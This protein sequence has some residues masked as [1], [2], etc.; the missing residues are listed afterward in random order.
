MKQYLKTSREQSTH[1]RKT[2]LFPEY[3]TETL[4]R[5]LSTV[6]PGAELHHSWA[7]PG[8]D[9]QCSKGKSHLSEAGG[10][11]SKNTLSLGTF[12]KLIVKSNLKAEE[13]NVKTTLITMSAMPSSYGSSSRWAFG[14]VFLIGTSFPF[15]DCLWACTVSFRAAGSQLICAWG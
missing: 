11:F 13:V 1:L 9:T 12:L 3:E 10:P 7:L 5:P 15:T 2:I 8:T 4:W 6:D 14:E